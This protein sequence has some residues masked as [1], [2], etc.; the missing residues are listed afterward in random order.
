[1]NELDK[2]I[3]LLRA[4]VEKGQTF[5]LTADDITVKVTGDGNTEVVINS[6]TIS[7]ES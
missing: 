7:T 6:P 3:D 5:T 4:A 1:M 2:L